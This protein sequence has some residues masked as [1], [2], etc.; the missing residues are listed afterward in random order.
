[1]ISKINL[2][3]FKTILIAALIIRCLAAVFSEGY[4]MHDDHFLI[5]E[6]SASWAD[7][8]DYNNWLPWNMSEGSVP[9]G[10]S[11][12]YVGLNFFFFYVAKGV[13]IVDPKILMFFNRLIHAL[14]SILIVY[15]GF[16]IT[17]KLS[18]RKNAVI[19]GW[20]L[21]LGWLFPFIGVR[22]LVEVTCIPFIMWSTWIYLK[23]NTSKALLLA[24]IIMGMAVSFRYQVGVYAIGVA[25]YFL[26]KKEF[27][28]FFFYCLGVLI[29]FIITQ[30]L[31][32]Y[33]IWG[34]PFAEMYGYIIYNLNEGTEYLPNQNFLMYIEVLMG[35]ML[36]PLGIVLAIGYFRSFKKYL[37]LFLPSLLFLIFHSWYPSKQERFIFPILPMFIMLGVIGYESLKSKKSYN[38]IWNISLKAFWILNIPVLLFVSFTYSKKSRVEAMYYFYENNIT[39]YSVMIEG[40][41]DNHTS[42]MPKFYVG[43]WDFLLYYRTTLELEEFVDFEYIIF[44]NSDQLTE[45][46]GAYKEMFPNMKMV[47][48]CEASYADKIAKW[49][50]PRNRN[51]YFE[52]W[53]TNYKPKELN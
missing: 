7:G 3:S 33:L 32:D 44:S 39:P 17:E 1:M 31:V 23:S 47:K 2:N 19:V 30:G 43:D 38:K 50:N 25:I 15:Y 49:L 37:I 52:V 22:N 51:E 9:E 12:S 5:V 14:F 41:G 8:N 35:A 46:I 40:S 24:G 27:R 36:F 6:S 21:S 18:N 29:T 16:K 28:E 10:H 48:S 4:G 20:I 11:F 42:Q 34:Y 26:F 53:A 13:G 45:R